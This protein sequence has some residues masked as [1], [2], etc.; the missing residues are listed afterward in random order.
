MLAALGEGARLLV[1]GDGALDAVE[2]GE[3]LRVNVD[4]A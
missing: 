1:Q 4:S 3:G 2:G